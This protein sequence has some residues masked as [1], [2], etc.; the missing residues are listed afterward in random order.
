MKS[1]K[2]VIVAAGYG[3]RFLPITKSIPKE[4]LPLI[5]RPAIEF[6]INEFL[7]SGI[8][9]IVIISSRRKKVMEDYFDR[10]LELEE[11]FQKEGAFEKH[12]KLLRASEL[13]DVHFIRQKEMKG[14]AHAIYLAHAFI[15]TSPFVVAY[16]DDL[17]LCDIPLS[18]QLIMLFEKTNKNVLSALEIPKK[19]VSRYGII[20]PEIAP[21]GT[22]Y[23]KDMVEKPPI[24][25]A[26]SN[27]MSAGR[28]LF[29]PEILDIFKEQLAT[30][31]NGELFQTVG[32]D[33]LAKRKQVVA[34]I[35]EGERLDTGEPI[36]YIKAFTRYALSRPEY[37]A[38]YLKF[39]ES[40]IEKGI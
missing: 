18:K 6:I 17:F 40:I 5:D 25:K 19:E 9:D 16:P 15:G 37:Q 29:K 1:L 12:H 38:S 3:T 31:K 33:I 27:L 24:D 23:V 39:L 36:S 4:M 26:P 32:I 28:Y 2:G 13:A 11:I 7:D 34:K 14:T 10:D 30:H 8:E 21:D 20:D 22:L 35:V